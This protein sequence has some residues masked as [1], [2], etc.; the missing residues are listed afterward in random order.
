MVNGSEQNSKNLALANNAT[1]DMLM[2]ANI[3]KPINVA[4]IKRY[5]IDIAVD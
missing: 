3:R 5:W 2:T 4:G 1:H